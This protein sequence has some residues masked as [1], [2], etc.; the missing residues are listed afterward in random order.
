MI[1]GLSYVDLG[2]MLIYFGIII[3]IGIRASFNIKSQEDYLL[4]GR[5]FGKLTS[6]F[7][8]FGQAT[9]ADGPAGVAT[10]TFNN[11]ASGIWSSLLML[12]VTPLFWI[13]APWLRRLRMLTMGDF[14]LERYGSKKM[15][16]T[17]AIIASIGMMGLLSVGYM[18]VSKTAQAMTPKSIESLSQDE[19]SERERALELKVL[20]SKDL[21]SLSQ[22]E[23]AQLDRLR[24]EKPRSLFSHLNSGYLIWGICLLVILYTVLGGLEAAIYT[25]LLQGVFIVFLSIILLPFAWSSIN[26]RYGGEGVLNALENLHQNLPEHFFEIFGSPQTIDFTWYFILT[27]ALVSGITVVTQPNQLV[28]AGAAKDEMSARVGFVTGT[29]MKRV[30]TVLWGM[31]G[32]AAILLYSGEITNSDLVWGHATRELLGSLNIGLVG[33]MLASMMAALMSTADC[34]MLTVSGLIV[35]NLYKP[36]FPNA[37]ESRLIFVGRIAGA[38]FLIGG[39]IITTQ[40]DDILQILKFIWEFFVIFAA[41]FWLGLKWRK[42]NAT[43]AWLS[44]GASF[45]IFYLIPILLPLLFPQLKTSPTLLK[46]TAP[47]PIE[48]QYAVKSM[49]IDLR[50]K[51]I[52]EWEANSVVIASTPRPTELVLGEPYTKSFQLPK[53]SIFW[54]KKVKT[55]DSGVLEGSGYIYLELVLINA[56]GFD[57]SKNPFALNESIRMLIRLIFPFILLILGSLLWKR[58][59]DQLL[60][61]FYSKM[62]TPVSEESKSRDREIVQEAR[63]NFTS[64]E[65]ILVFPKS[66]WEFYKWKKLDWTG[67]ILAWVMVVLVLMMLYFAV[68]VGN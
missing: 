19:V 3:Y 12:F 60:I 36:F 47:P 26:D 6:T 53:K 55:N 59:E 15:A 38:S 5:K 52:K 8:S 1:L 66:D 54:S 41:A 27:A 57:L 24:I 45:A 51:E 35:S 32:L 18:A 29:F 30:I 28:T 64:T 58:D 39:A 21:L 43:G 68:T 44:I 67:F 4:G 20:E 65:S 62:R 9:S 23:K 7:A 37:S 34:L 50:N 31:L 56:L 14:Y 49:D 61:D 33:L 40:F 13:T 17:Y 22:T 48:R 25:D 42:A 16:A 11:G 2:I 46:Q 63:E 10:T